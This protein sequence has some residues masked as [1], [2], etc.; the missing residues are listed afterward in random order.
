MLWGNLLFKDATPVRQE[1]RAALA[2]VLEFKVYGLHATGS[3]IH[4]MGGC[5]GW[6]WED[7]VLHSLVFTLSNDSV[8]VGPVLPLGKEQVVLSFTCCMVSHNWF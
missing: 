8:L 3:L 6:G 7:A 5:G 2:G 4:T 1:G